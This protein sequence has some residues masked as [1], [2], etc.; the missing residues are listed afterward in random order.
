MEMKGNRVAT[1][2][3]L[4]CFLSSCAIPSLGFVPGIKDIPDFR[5][6]TKVSTS[7]VPGILDS[8]FS[9]SSEAFFEC[10]YQYSQG[11]ESSWAQIS[12]EES[13]CRHEGATSF[14]SYL[15]NG[16]AYFFQMGEKDKVL[17]QE[18]V[19][20]DTL[21]Q[22]IASGAA[23]ALERYADSLSLA[24][25]YYSSC[26]FQTGES[27]VFDVDAVSQDAYYRI[28]LSST[29]QSQKEELTLVAKR[30]EL[31]YRLVSTKLSSSESTSSYW[32]FATPTNLHKP[33][34]IAPLPSLASSV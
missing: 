1:A 18:I 30:I 28:V 7:R 15:G 29:R 2:S 23:L 17:S 24:V 22:T 10:S 3:I 4:S 34:Y 9:V 33:Q 26:D 5:S 27:P 25:N 6:S 11:K 20:F 31:S 19:E 8:L 13:Y 16:E 21:S 32:S 12:A 14:I